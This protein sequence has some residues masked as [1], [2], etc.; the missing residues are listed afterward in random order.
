MYAGAD[1]TWQFWVGNGSPVGWVQLF[2]P[3]VVLNTWTH[4]VGTFDGSTVRFYVNGVLAGSASTGFSVNAQRPLR[5]A[6]GAT[7]G[8]AN[9]WL[10][11][12]VDEVSVYGAALPAARVQAHYSAGTGT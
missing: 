9:S 1:N 3:S 12:R 8:A 7:E 11:G 2:G 4:L 5:I 6:A 10:P